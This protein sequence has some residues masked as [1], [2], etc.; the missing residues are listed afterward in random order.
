MAERVVVRFEVIDVEHDEREGRAQAVGLGEEELEV[1]TE[2]ASVLGAG[3]LING[4]ELGQSGVLLG[5]LLVD[6]QNPFRDLETDGKL[7]GVGRLG[8]KVVGAARRPSSLS[9]RRSREVRR[10]MYV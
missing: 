10:M 3:Q 9:S 8:Q 7:I 5:Q 6:G 2:S 1:L 4:G